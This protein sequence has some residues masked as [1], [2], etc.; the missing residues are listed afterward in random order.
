MSSLFH[1]RNLASIL[2]PMLL[3]LPLCSQAQNQFVLGELQPGQLLLNLNATEQEEVDQDTLNINLQFSVQGRDRIQLQNEVNEALRKTIAL[4]EAD[5]RVKFSTTQYQ[6]YTI[7]AGR[8]SRTDVENPVWL[9]QQ[10]ISLASIDSAA[11]LE[12]TGQLQALGLT[13]SAQYYSLSA[14]R[15]EEVA[16][17]LLDAALIKL[18]QRADT[19]A[20]SLGKNRAELVEVS[21][22]GSPNFAYLEKGMVM[23]MRGAADMATPVA[24]PGETTVSMSV[25]ARAVLY[26]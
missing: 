22:D 21:L 23:A 6:V 1:A 4:L 12:L 3:A 15:Y 7:E 26:P 20:G 10:G 2:L 5:G 16:A 17:R 8:P 13:V 25:S 18:Q 14:A 9:A 11:V 24:A 19:A